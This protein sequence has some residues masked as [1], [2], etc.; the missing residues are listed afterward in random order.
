MKL[1]Q[2]CMEEVRVLRDLDSELGPFAPYEER[3][4]F[5]ELRRHFAETYGLDYVTALGNMSKYA[6]RSA[7]S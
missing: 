2:A 3:R 1:S 4:A 6:K 7:G 5:L